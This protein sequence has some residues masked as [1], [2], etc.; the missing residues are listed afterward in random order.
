M[1]RKNEIEA[2]ARQ[3]LI[4]HN[5][6]YIPVDPIAVAK[7]LGVKVV[8]AKFSDNE[9]SGL[10]SKRDDQKIIYLN[11][12]DSNVRKRFTIAHELGHCLLHMEDKD[13]SEITDSRI[14]FRPSE[15]LTPKS[16]W[17]EERRNEWEANIFA[18]ALLMNEE[19]VRKSTS[20]DYSD[21]GLALDFQV[22]VQAMLIRL[23]TLGIK[24]GES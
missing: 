24:I 15:T 3:V 17:S 23:N 22:S 21:E 9:I 10:I 1:N 13:I 18:A 7:A 16:S 20:Q 19:L 5:L 14:N 4:D 8:S 2:L 6:L 11:A 12:D